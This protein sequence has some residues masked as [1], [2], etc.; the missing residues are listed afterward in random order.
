MKD[1][2]G[3]ALLETLLLSFILVGFS[4]IIYSFHLAVQTEKILQVRT[5][6]LFLAEEEM[7]YLISMRDDGEL[8]EGNYDFLGETTEVN[9]IDYI[10]K[11]DVK[12]HAENDDFLIAKVSVKWKIFH[13]ERELHLERLIVTQK[14][15]VPP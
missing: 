2:R 13:L 4:A 15:N 7:A 10:V 3:F 8:T 12:K 11:A 6:A 1:E 9:N 5:E 14:K